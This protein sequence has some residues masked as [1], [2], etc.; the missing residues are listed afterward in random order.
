MFE[1]ILPNQKAILEGV[2][3]AKKEYETYIE[4]LK[5]KKKEFE[6]MRGECEGADADIDKAL[7]I[8]DDDIADMEKDYEKYKKDAE[9]YMTGDDADA[10]KETPDDV[11]TNYGTSD[12]EEPTESPEEMEV[13]IGEEPAAEEPAMDA[14]VAA[15][16]A[17]AQQGMY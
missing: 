14:D 7:S 3:E 12:T 16:A 1:D 15:M 11:A 17:A 6:A 2:E 4:E 9:Q 5:N 8:I 13:P 10:E